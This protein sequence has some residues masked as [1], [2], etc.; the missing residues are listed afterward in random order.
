MEEEVSDQQQALTNGINGSMKV[1]E[2]N[3]NGGSHQPKEAEEP[4]RLSTRQFAEQKNYEPK[5]LFNKVYIK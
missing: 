5:E 4:N 1:S 2:S 3:G